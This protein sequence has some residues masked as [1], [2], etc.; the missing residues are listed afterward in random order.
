MPGADESLS[1]SVLA[2]REGEVWVAQCIEYDISTLQKI[3]SHA[4]L[5]LGLFA[6]AV[7]ELAKFRF[8][9]LRR[10]SASSGQL[11]ARDVHPAR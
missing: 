2:F 7:D 3:L 8:A 4:A 9:A 5:L 10:Q 6:T 1:V 11:K